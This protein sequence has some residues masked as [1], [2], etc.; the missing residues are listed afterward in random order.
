M[1]TQRQERFD[2]F[3]AHQNSLS[4]LIRRQAVET[5]FFAVGPGYFAAAG[6]P[7]LKGRVLDDAD[8]AGGT[9]VVGI[10]QTMADRFIAGADPIGRRLLVTRGD[11]AGVKS[12]GSSATSSRSGS[13]STHRRRSTSRTCSIRT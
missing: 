11:N 6:T 2:S 1:R 7:L 8:R 3:L 12:S 10:N 9:R 5:N 4:T 13:P